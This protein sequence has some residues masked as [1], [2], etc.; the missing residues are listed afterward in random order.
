MAVTAFQYSNAPYIY[1]VA[2]ANV[3]TIIYIVLIIN[4]PLL[5]NNIKSNTDYPLKE[6]T[7]LCAVHSKIERSIE[8]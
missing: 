8:T 7:N 3:I 2:V 6:T 1:Y 4:K 5:T